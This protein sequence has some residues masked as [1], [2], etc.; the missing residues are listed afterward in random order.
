MN[1]TYYDW[2][3]TLNLNGGRI[4]ELSHKGIRIFGTYN[5]IDGKVGNT[6]I[7][8]PSFDK[9][10]QEKYGLPFHGL[11]RNAKWGIKSQ[12]ASS[13]AISCVTPS[14]SLY[15]AQLSV[16]QEFILENSFQ[17]VIHVT[18][19]QGEKVPVNIACHYYWDT[20]QGWKT[21]TLNDQDVREKIETN[22][23][24]D[25]KKDNAIIFPHVTYQM[26]ADNFRS[27]VL[28]TSFKTDGQENK[29]F[30]NDFCCIEPVME[31]PHFFGS[32]KS[33]LIP[34]KTVSASISIEKVV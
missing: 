12:S 21:T 28:W 32:E 2:S 33:I 24:T 23:Y 27:A 31:W 15:P 4:K 25:L 8:V 17:H 14:S 6:H 22:G 9:E 1:L 18:N 29:Q 19:I 11:V 26:Q 5:R 30:S 13:I 20:P 10:G 34:G 7:C 16:E 3:L